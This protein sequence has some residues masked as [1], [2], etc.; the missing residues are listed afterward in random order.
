MRRRQLLKSAGA[1]LPTSL[2][3]GCLNEN[4]LLWDQSQPQQDQSPPFSRPSAGSNI[5]RKD[6]DYVVDTG[7][8]FVESLSSAQSGDVV[9]VDPLTSIDLTDREDVTIPGGVTLASGESS[10]GSS[11]GEIVTNGTPRPLL[12]TDGNGVRFTG[13]RL[14]G[15]KSEGVFMTENVYEHDAV[16][17]QSD[18]ANTVIDNCEVSNFTHS[19]I[20]CTGSNERVY[21]CKIHD[22]AMS[23]LGYGI[24][25]ASSNVLIEYNYFNANRHSVTATGETTDE[26]IYRYNVHGPDTLRS[27]LDV[28]CPGGKRFVIHANQFR[29]THNVNGSPI[30]AV[31]VCGTPS[32]TCDV[33]HNFFAHTEPPGETSDRGDA[34][35]QKGTDGWENLRYWGNQYGNEP[36]I[37]GG[38]PPSDP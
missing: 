25:V 33:S 38:Q 28:H 26:Y 6:A 1:V 14:R 22:N 16:G 9:F 19:G 35:W 18:H 2:L 24:T 10:D 5:N 12:R 11:V 21:R 31:F 13:L 15:P 27:A 36:S 20:M 3:A 34:I 30:S 7:S 23:G 17:I 8:R 37:D 32:E 29:F 4:T